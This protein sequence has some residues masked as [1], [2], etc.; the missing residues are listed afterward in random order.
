MAGV[1]F[2][3]LCRYNEA[4]S[5]T[6][7]TPDLEITW[8]GHS[9]F[10]L[11]ERGQITI[12]TDPYSDTIGLPPQRWKGDVVTTSHQSPGHAAVE[13]VKGASHTL[14]GPGEYEIGGVFMHGIAMHHIDHEQQI[15]KPNI[16]FLFE[17]GTGVNVLHLG[18]LAHIPDQSTIEQMGEVDVLLVPVGGGNGLKAPTAAEVIGLIE[19]TYIVPMHYALPGLALDLD[20]L[21]K[22][23]KAI[24]VS[25]VQEEETLRVTASG[26]P[27]QPQVVVL[28]PQ[29]K[30]A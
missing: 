17:F 14:S 26:Q 8:Y 30:G 19:P 20:P 10:R 25:R 5:A 23:L 6:Q 2:G 18:D 27:E 15:I 1:Y 11:A 3:G 4:V 16:A 7:R 21:E 28:T 24:G 9:C 12:I 22:F 29:F 13:N